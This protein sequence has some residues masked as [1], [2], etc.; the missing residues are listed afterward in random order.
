M[1]LCFPT[2]DYLTNPNWDGDPSNNFG[3]N[4]LLCFPSFHCIC[5]FLTP[6]AAIYG[7][8][9]LN[10]NQQVSFK[11]RMV[12]GYYLGITG[13]FSILIYFSTLFLK[14]HYIFDGIF[15]LIIIVI[16]SLTV[17]GVCK[18]RNSYNLITDTLFAKLYSKIQFNKKQKTK[19]IVVCAASLI[20]LGLAL[21]YLIYICIFL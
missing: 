21:Y 19:Q 17:Y 4:D 1:Y 11:R 7:Y 14:Q 16:A 20:L 5:S 8:T 15:S 3:M 12:Q 2:V 10:G 9:K 18:Y 13:I 6:I